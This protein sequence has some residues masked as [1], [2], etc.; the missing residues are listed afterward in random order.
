MPATLD[1]VFTTVLF[2]DPGKRGERLA[3][4][5]AVKLLASAP[6]FCPPLVLDPVG[7]P[8]WGTLDVRCEDR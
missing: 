5:F 8:T 6:I 4:R 7:I 1:A 3:E 2:N